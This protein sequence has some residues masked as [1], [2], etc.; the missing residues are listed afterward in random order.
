[1]LYTHVLKMWTPCEA[2]V[3]ACCEEARGLRGV[4]WSLRG[5][6]LSN[7]TCLTRVFFKSDES[8]S[9]LR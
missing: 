6:H 3:A 7:T 5:S 2:A 4:R 8:C 9:S 1:M